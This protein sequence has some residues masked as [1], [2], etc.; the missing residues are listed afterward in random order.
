MANSQ[1]DY[2]TKRL[3]ASS[4]IFCALCIASFRCA[5]QLEYTTDV[6][7]QS[8]R[9]NSRCTNSTQDISLQNASAAAHYERFLTSG[10]YGDDVSTTRNAP[11]PK[12]LNKYPAHYWADDKKSDVAVAVILSI[13]GAAVLAFCCCCLKGC[14]YPK[15][16]KSVQRYRDSRESK[17]FVEFPEYSGHDD[18]Y[19]ETRYQ[20]SNHS[21]TKER[22]S[23]NAPSQR[24][25]V[26]KPGIVYL[27]YFDDPHPSSDEEDYGSLHSARSD[28]D[29]T[30]TTRS[31]PNLP[32]PSLA[33]VQYAAPPVGGTASLD[34]DSQ[35]PAR[36]SQTSVT[37]GKTTT[38]NG[39]KN[40]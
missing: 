32:I 2:V 1:S 8:L 24:V 16:C 27:D 13:T 9:T 10:P 28:E 14:C 30:L 21:H 7:A 35:L 23:G 12:N 34:S 15:I 40:T 37:N 20:E 39:T 22:A 31:A 33:D 29:W 4:L 38:A 19:D 3:L 5:D 11:T 26:T 36:V 25:S 17:L 18:T 6:A